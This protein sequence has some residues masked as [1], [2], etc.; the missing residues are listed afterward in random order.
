MKKL[1]L[2]LL[3][4]M[5]ALFASAAEVANIASP[6]QQVSCRVITLSGKAYLDVYNAEGKRMTRITLGLRTSGEQFTSLSVDTVFA[7]EV[8]TENYSMLHGK[9]SN[10]S[11][12]ATAIKMRFLNAK[13]SELGVEVRAWNDGVTFRYSLPDNG[14]TRT[15]TGEATSYSIEQTDHRW[16]MEYNT[17]Y[18][19]DFPYQANASRQADWAFP[20]LFEHKGYFMLITEANASRRYCNT[21]L[22]NSSSL[23]NYAVSYPYSW[24]GNS[25]GE[26]NPTWEGEWTSPWRVV[27]V[28]DLQTIATS[29][30]VEDCSDPTQMTDLSWIKP[31]SAAWVYWA[32]NHGTRD[33]QICK[34][35]VDLAY[36]MGWEYVLFDWEWD[37]M[38]NGGNIQDACKYAVSKGIKPMMWYNSG[39][40]H[41]GVGATPRDRMLTHENRVAEF[42][43]LKNMGVVG[44]KIDFF[45]S[46]KQHMMNYYLDILED[47]RD[48][49]ML[50]NFHGATIP[51]GWTR[52][53]PHLMSTEGVFGAEQYNNGSHMTDNAPRINC[54]FPFTRN[55]VGP[56][57][58]TPV[59]F[60]N[61]Q[62]PHTTTYA[63]ELALAVVFESG[64]QHWA[65]RPEGFYALPGEPMQ[66]MKEIPTAW[67]ET[68]LVGG[69]PGQFVIMARRKGDL[70]YVGGLE[71]KSEATTFSVPL[72]FLDEGV[73][74]LLVL[75]ADG[76]TM[77]DF[78]SSY[79]K[80]KKGDILEVPCLS[81]GGFT[82]SIKPER[83]YGYD[84]LVSLRKDITSAV[85][86]AKTTKATTQA[87]YD[88]A[89]IT[90]LQEALELSKQTTADNTPDEILSAYI[91]LQQA[92][93]RFQ[94]EAYI[95]GGPIHHQELTQNVTAKYL[96]EARM[97]T[98]AEDDDVSK[99]YGAPKYWTVENYNVD[100]DSEGA[101]QGID[102]Y[103]GWN[104]LSLG[105]WDDSQNA[106]GNLRNTKLYRTVVLPAGKYFLGGNYNSTLGMEKG[107]LFA[108]KNAAP[109]A[110]TT[111]SKA[112]FCSLISQLG[113]GDG[114]N[115]ITFTLDEESTVTLGWNADLTTSG[116]CEFR[117]NEIQL[118]R[119]LDAE[120]EWIVSE[121]ASVTH[122]APL[123]VSAP[124]FADR[125]TAGYAWGPKKEGILNSSDGTILTVGQIDLTGIDAITI[126]G[127]L[128]GSTKSGSK[129]EILL[130]NANTEWTTVPAL[131]TKTSTMQTSTNASVPA[132]TGVHTVKIRVKGATTNV[133]GV[134][135]ESRNGET[136]IHTVCPEQNEEPTTDYTL[137]GTK[138]FINTSGVVIRNGKKTLK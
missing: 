27:I 101:K 22:S 14:K 131:K 60:T 74:Y 51:R 80:V 65:D 108:A 61:S 66:F 88:K 70:W 111:P 38:Y 104:S 121:A 36:K 119:Y 82:M 45:E 107:Y 85:S 69:Y 37:S 48:A 34:A 135:F 127:N 52:T 29:T 28:G 114:L 72:D 123:Y 3:L 46:D 120:E 47:A 17:S 13:Q 39:G 12:E 117:A 8:I 96:V 79:K 63:H 93:S 95:T 6:N 62:H 113:T 122:D 1:Y 130:D 76:A 32:Y 56:M 90:L 19:G 71:G 64:I 132:M 67:D 26:V 50:V 9:R 83:Y 136:A 54:T 116:N 49:K 23:N 7:P 106:V 105:V 102:T 40:P 92:Y 68:R 103:T 10:V 100:K 24:E 30:L 2:S 55:V 118:L 84:N 57:D 129:F 11:N 43:W 138:A 5:S 94:S 20:C 21:H 77:S 87:Y 53:Y 110:S 91:A 4:L 15:F 99:R 31:G 112:I 86:K 124:A 137:S 98:R 89:E 44:V 128:P 58:Y 126:H 75:N 33:F 59:A 133:W 125:G 18:E 35:Y 81:R 115:G 109:T 41:N 78:N 25:M 134:T 73:S 97:F 42:K 16:L